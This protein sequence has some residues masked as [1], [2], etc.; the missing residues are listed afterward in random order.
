MGFRGGIAEG[1]AGELGVVESDP[2]QCCDQHLGHRG[3]PEP[4]LASR[5]AISSSGQRPDALV[6]ALSGSGLSETDKRSFGPPQSETSQPPHA[7]SRNP[8]K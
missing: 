3:E 8:G 2:A 6:Q 4:E 5:Y 1:R 7:G